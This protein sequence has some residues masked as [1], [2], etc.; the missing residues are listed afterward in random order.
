MF[1]SPPLGLLLV[2]L[3]SHTVTQH[4]IANDVALESVRVKLAQCHKSINY[5]L[6]QLKKNQNR[7]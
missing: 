2:L 6:A 7:A 4:A 3:R 1:P 5:T